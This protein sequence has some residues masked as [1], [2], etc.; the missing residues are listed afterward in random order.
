MAGYYRKFVQHFGIIAK[1]LT[2]FMKKNKMF[3]WTSDQE[4]TFSTFKATLISAPVLLL[5]DFSKPFAIETD[6]SDWCGSY[7]DAG[8]SP[9]CLCK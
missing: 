9:N 4:V 3:V 7:I 6:A 1:S 5:L 8:S 2:E